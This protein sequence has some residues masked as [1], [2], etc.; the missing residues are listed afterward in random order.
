MQNNID[1]FKAIISPNILI[2][3]YFDFFFPSPEISPYFAIK[4][5]LFNSFVSTNGNNKLYKK[6]TI[7]KT[8]EFIETWIPIWL[9]IWVYIELTPKVQWL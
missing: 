8:T 2:K 5:Y 4:H 3:K 6:Y 1:I 9:R 7:T